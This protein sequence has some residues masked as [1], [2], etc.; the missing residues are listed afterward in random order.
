MGGGGGARAGS[1]LPLQE[2]QGLSLVRG[3]AEPH[4]QKK[5]EEEAEEI[6]YS[7]MNLYSKYFLNLN[8]FHP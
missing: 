6:L 5:K 2:T 1:Q 4:I 7:E 3:H 8:F